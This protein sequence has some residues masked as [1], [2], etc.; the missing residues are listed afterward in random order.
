M[1]D[2]EGPELRTPRYA[3]EDVSE[4][5][6]REIRGWYFYGLAAEVYAVCGVGRFMPFK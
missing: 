1:E 5:T 4:T 6:P 2:I 3:G